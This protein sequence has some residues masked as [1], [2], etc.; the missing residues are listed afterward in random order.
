[1]IWIVNPFDDLPGEGSGPLRYW[2]LAQVAAEQGA[3]VV[4]WSSDFSHRRKAKR[5]PPPVDLPFEVELVPTPPYRRNVGLARMRNHRQFARGFEA[6]AV[7]AVETG[8]RSRPTHVIVSS[9]PLGPAEVAFRLRARWGC[10]VVVDIMDAWPETFLRVIPGGARVRGIVGQALLRPLFQAAGRAYRG[11]DGV[12]AV[13]DTYLNL[14]RERG[15]TCPMKLCYHGA[16]FAGLDDLCLDCRPEGPLR[17]VYIGAMGASYDLE[18]V[19]RALKKA[20]QNGA[21]IDFRLAGGGCREDGLK[22][23]SRELGFRA[24]GEPVAGGVRVTFCGYLQRAELLEL[25]RA[26]DVGVIPLL[27][28]SWVA[29]PYKVGDY[30]AAG[31]AVLSGLGGE[32]ELLLGRYQAG[33]GYRPGDADALAALLTEYARDPERLAGHRRNSRR[34]AEELFDRRATYPDLVKFVCNV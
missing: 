29:L 31:L 13:S 1:V 26:A 28:E 32:L 34:M 20:G 33:G 27:P 10:K 3:E 6:M 30:T 15:A 23:L 14:A 24:E 8:R 7:R 5:V 25:L 2:T 11:A 4:W 9:P 12:S 16:D 22:R 18:S 19:F 17:L 21:R